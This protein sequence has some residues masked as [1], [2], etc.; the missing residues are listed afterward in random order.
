M[1]TKKTITELATKLQT[2]EKNVAREYC[3]HLF[4]SYFYKKDG[5]EK[6][7]FKG[8]TAL[9]I[10]F[11]SPRFSEDL[12]FSA[13]DENPA[14]I[15]EINSLVDETLK[16]IREEGIECEKELNPGTQGETTG[17]YFAI[18]K[19][20]LFEFSSEIK[21][22]ISFRSLEKVKGNSSLI[23]NDFVSSYVVNH[24]TE[25]ILVEEKINALLSRKKSRDLFDLYFILR[26]RNL[27]K[28]IPR[29]PEL[30]EKLI[31]S[32]NIKNLEELKLLLPVSN[33]FILAGFEERVKREIDT[34]I[35]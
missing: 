29:E 32:I 34:Y 6:I 8:G 11:G 9:R 2:S 30:K 24:L 35:P 17:G 16:D 18:I 28:Y 12:D 27:V 15:P 13:L 20:G 31:D 26:N 3:Q 21:L 4:L 19:F 10:I 33:R 22:Q 5:S 23:A 14:T 25:S 1:I 7:L